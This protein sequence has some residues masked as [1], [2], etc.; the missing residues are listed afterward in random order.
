MHSCDRLASPWDCQPLED[1][2]IMISSQI[3]LV[4]TVV[5]TM[6]SCSGSR[7]MMAWLA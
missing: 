2:N 3:E 6:N 7:A 1:P 5:S 4:T